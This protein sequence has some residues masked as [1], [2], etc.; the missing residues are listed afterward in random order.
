MCFSEEANDSVKVSS[1]FV[2]DLVNVE[3]LTEAE[4]K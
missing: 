4:A 3:C 2:C 1:V